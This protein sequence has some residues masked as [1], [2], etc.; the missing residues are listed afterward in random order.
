MVSFKFQNPSTKLQ[1]ITKS[2]ISM[3]KTWQLVIQVVCP[4]SEFVNL[5]I[6]NNPSICSEL[7][8][9]PV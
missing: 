7:I 4:D 1:I 9:C 3:T 2:E 8:A 6:D 5:V